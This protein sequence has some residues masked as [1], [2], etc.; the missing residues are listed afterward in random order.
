M[1]LELV[2]IYLLE[3]AKLFIIFL[4]I[5]TLLDFGI[6]QKEFN[7]QQSMR[8]HLI[9]AAIFGL[10]LGVIRVIKVRGNN[11]KEGKTE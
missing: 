8:S 2:K 10:I 11:K 4:F 5:R 3:A 9:A 7:I 1:N 6:D